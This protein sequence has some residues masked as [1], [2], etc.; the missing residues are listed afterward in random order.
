MP[1]HPVAIELLREAGPTAVS[2]ANRTGRPPAL[3]ADSAIEQLGT[4]VACY[5][6]GGPS[7][8]T[9]ASSIVD[10]TS[11]TPRMLREGALT[12]ELLREVVPELVGVG[13][14]AG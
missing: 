8:D 12:L 9:T 5:L 6:D 3:D 4:D 10:L 1:L 11:G 7:G 13:E 14:Q 2:S